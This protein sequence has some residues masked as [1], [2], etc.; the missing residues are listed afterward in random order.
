M[1]DKVKDL[2]ALLRQID[3]CEDTRFQKDCLLSNIG[4]FFTCFKDAEINATL[5][6][7]FE[8]K[9]NLKPRYEA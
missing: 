8:D 1:E 7:L 3:K 4:H 5:L 2:M 9:F 6:T